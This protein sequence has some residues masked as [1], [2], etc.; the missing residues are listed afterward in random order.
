MSEQITP[1]PEDLKRAWHLWQATDDDGEMKKYERDTA[2]DEAERGL[3]QVRHKAIRDFM[4]PPKWVCN[5]G[6]DVVGVCTEDDKWPHTSAFGCGWRYTI[7]IAKA[8]FEQTW[9]AR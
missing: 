9:G 7:D 2:Y 3:A 4:G 8:G 6:P 1:T 5:G